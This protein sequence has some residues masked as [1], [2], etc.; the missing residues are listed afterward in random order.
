MMD[1]P[2]INRWRKALTENDVVKGSVVPDFSKIF[3]NNLRK[4]NSYATAL[5]DGT[6]AAE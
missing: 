6:I 1:F 3:E 5:L 2:E 4:R